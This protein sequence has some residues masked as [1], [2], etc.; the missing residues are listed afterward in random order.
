MRS[1][2]RQLLSVV[3]GTFVFVAAVLGFAAPASAHDAA[4]SSSPAQGAT[5]A[6]APEQVSVTFNKNPLGIGAQFSVKDSAGA[7]WADG[8]L[9][10]VDSTATQKLKAGAPA[11]AYTVVWRVVSSDSHPIEGTFGFTATAAAAGAAPS[12][13]SAGASPSAAIPTMGSAEPG[14]VA[15]P[16][17]AENASQPF[18]WS[19]VIFAAVAVGLLVAIGIL[20]KRRLTT[21]SDDDETEQA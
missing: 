4:E 14:T 18:P 11:G 7:E 20:A 16:A 17:P 9:E 3:L 8:A 2:R 12:G 21:R 5:V 1:I 15:A 10:I 19:L 6:T 13:T